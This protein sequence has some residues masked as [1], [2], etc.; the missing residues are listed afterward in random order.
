MTACHWRVIPCEKIFQDTSLKERDGVVL[1]FWSK[2]HSKDR[3]QNGLFFVI[4]R[5]R[6]FRL[7]NF[8]FV[9]DCGVFQLN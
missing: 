2:K 5:K 7:E 1:Q 6:E 3:L 8:S 9:G 4:K